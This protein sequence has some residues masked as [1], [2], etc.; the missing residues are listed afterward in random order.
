M[1]RP[2]RYVRDILE[3]ISKNQGCNIQTLVKGLEHEISR[4]TIF[5]TLNELR[6]QGQVTVGRKKPNSRDLNLYVKENN[7]LYSVPKE[8]EEFEGLFI[9]FL[10]GIS[11]QNKRSIRQLKETLSMWFQNR[12]KELGKKENE[13]LRLNEIKQLIEHDFDIQQEFD[14]LAYHLS[15]FVKA[16]AIFSQFSQI[17]FVRH[18]L[19]WSIIIRDKDLLDKLVSGVFTKIFDIQTQMIEIIKSGTA[20]NIPDPIAKEALEVKFFNLTKALI[21]TMGGSQDLDEVF[22]FYKNAHLEN[23]VKPIV[24][25]LS[26]TSKNLEFFQKDS[27]LVC[28][29]PISDPLSWSAE[30]MYEF[31]NPGKY[32]EEILAEEYDDEDSD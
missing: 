11:H 19:E 31:N 4:Q 30:D 17:Y 6:T 5:N 27:D 25:F 24:K 18:M 13:K 8:L 32:H 15:L 26:K 1:L 23:E 2:K 14:E 16:I 9:P 21:K 28:D 29:L 7:P 3:F 22:Q 10:Q 12:K 20:D